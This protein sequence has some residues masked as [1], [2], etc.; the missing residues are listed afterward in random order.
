MNTK[1]QIPEEVLELL[2]WF[3]TNKL[4]TEDQK[5]FEKALNTYP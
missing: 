2:P 4:S 5:I 1:N 3:T